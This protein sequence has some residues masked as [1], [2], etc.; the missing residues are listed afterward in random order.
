MIIKRVFAAWRR[1]P[2]SGRLEMRWCALSAD[3]R[4]SEPGAECGQGGPIHEPPRPILPS[5]VV[6]RAASE[7]ETLAEEA[8]SPLAPG[9]L[10]KPGVREPAALA[11]INDYRRKP[12]LTSRADEPRGE[13]FGTAMVPGRGRPRRLGALELFRCRWTFSRRRFM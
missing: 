12:R 5:R 2:V 9:R 11:Y 7:S 10:R 13:R 1:N 8:S 4:V 3:L 6:A